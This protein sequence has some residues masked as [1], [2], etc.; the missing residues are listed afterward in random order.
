MA[1][2]VDK[3]YRD[4]TTLLGSTQEQLEDLIRHG[5]TFRTACAKAGV[6]YYT[7]HEWMMKGGDP[8][9]RSKHKC[10][11]EYQIEPYY[12]FARAIRDA[13]AEG[14]RIERPRIPT[15][16]QPNP[17]T[18]EQRAALLSGFAQGW[19]IR[20]IARSAGVTHNTL[21]SWLHRGGYPRAVS[22][23]VPIDPAGIM[24]PYKS[25]VE[26][27]LRAEDAFFTGDW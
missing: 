19:T 5:H 1:K 6:S 24:E 7:F 9:S 2:T 21:L 27:V 15:G 18:D 26:D 11:T 10:P 16:P 12:S 20:R 13:E 4:T 25:F 22:H 14:K 8:G 17:L 23:H 3:I